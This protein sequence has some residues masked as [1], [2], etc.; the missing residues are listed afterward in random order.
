MLGTA[1]RLLGEGCST[2][3][4]VGAP[5]ALRAIWPTGNCKRLGG[6]PAPRCEDRAGAQRSTPTAQLPGCSGFWPP[7]PQGYETGACSSFPEPQLRP[8][9]PFFRLQVHWL[10]MQLI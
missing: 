8:S 2:G 4:Q 10:T 9:P 7:T 6:S 3:W 1:A 5:E